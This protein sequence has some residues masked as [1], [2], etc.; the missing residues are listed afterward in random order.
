MKNHTL[1]TENNMS[2]SQSES[3]NDFIVETNET[4]DEFLSQNEVKRNRNSTNGVLEDTS[5]LSVSQDD[6]S[7]TQRIEGTNL[8]SQVK[9]EN[10]TDMNSDENSSLA[11]QSQGG[12]TWSVV[13]PNDTD[14][15][16][17]EDDEEA[18]TKSKSPTEIVTYILDRM[19]KWVDKDIELVKSNKPAYHK[20]MYSN[21]LFKQL[22]NNYV[23]EIFLANEGCETLSWWIDKTPDGNYPSLKVIETV[24][25]IVNVLPI[26]TEHLTQSKLGKI[27]KRL[28]KKCSSSRLR[29]KCKEILNKWYR[30]IFE[31]NS[32][33]DQAGIYEQQYRQ[34]RESKL[35]EIQEIRGTTK[36]LP[37]SKNAINEKTHDECGLIRDRVYIPAKNM[38]D[39]TYRPYNEVEPIEKPKNPDGIKS[40]ILKKMVRMQKDF[41]KMNKKINYD[42]KF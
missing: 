42:P 22:K 5:Q 7:N 21:K 23:Q 27:V 33:Y 15:T 17:T 34:Y 9:G 18:G 38:F 14:I 32:G 39:F 35:K 19:S 3:G 40:N 11:G 25:D 4:E 28:E 24:L 41:A 36:E 20:L 6:T 12:E 31:L 29:I 26:T 1:Q 16:A 10:L 13:Q 8:L 37:K 2:E 30:M